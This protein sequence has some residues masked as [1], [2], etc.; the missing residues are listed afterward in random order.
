MSGAETISIGKRV[1]VS[2]L[3]YKTSWQDL[4]KFGGPT[5]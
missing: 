2:N 1:Y 3:A 4:S 5:P